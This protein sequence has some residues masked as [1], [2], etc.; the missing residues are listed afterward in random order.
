MKKILIATIIVIIAMY[1]IS[2][3]FSDTENHWS[4]EY[5]DWAVEEKIVNGYED[6]TFKPNSEIKI[7]EFLKILTE[8]SKCKKEL[9]TKIWPDSYIAT[10]KAYEWIE[11]DEFDD[12]DKNITRDEAVKIISKYIDVSTVKK[13]SPKLKDLNSENKSNVLKLMELG[14]I[15]G[16]SDGTFKGNKT[17][18]RA[19]TLKL[20]KNAVDAHQSVI[21]QKKYD[22][23]TKITNVGKN[24]EGSLYRNRYEIKDNKIYFYDDGRYATLDGY[25]LESKNVDTGKIIKLI[26]N[27]VSED[28]YTSVNYVP[29]EKTISQLIIAHADR[30][31][32]LYNGTERFSI[33]FYPD[34]LYNL[35][36]VALE[37]S[38]SDKCFMKIRIAK[39]WYWRYELR[40]GT[41]LNE[42]KF[43]RVEKAVET[44][45]GREFMK[46][47]LPYLRQKVVDGQLREYNDKIKETI[48]IGQYRIDTYA[49]EGARVEFYISEI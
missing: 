15:N 42:N 28:T 37:E 32:Y 5:I 11:N 33:T 1:S 39:L 49:Y 14:V 44:I 10:A 34:K 19:E 30:E 24:R 13:S 35:K 21:N 41:Y 26:K 16:Y 48:Q 18:T 38:F 45:M 27:I 20:I 6:G 29:D 40:D 3:G 2:Y 23:T 17:I 4:K 8:A 9:T 47:F 12:Y 25:K 22:I 46:E 43:A 36:Q 7:N 31:S